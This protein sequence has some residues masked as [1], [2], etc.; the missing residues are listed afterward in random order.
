M[1]EGEYE[2]CVHYEFPRYAG[3]MVSGVQKIV[4]IEQSKFLNP[5]TKNQVGLYADEWHT[6]IKRKLKSV[7][8]FFKEAY[9]LNEGEKRLAHY[10]FNEEEM[11]MYNWYNTRT[12]IYDGEN[13]KDSEKGQ[14]WKI[15][16]A[17]IEGSMFDGFIFLYKV[18]K[19]R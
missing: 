17:K 9:P 8:K 11:M 13:L 10:I 19:Y 1:E 6:P 5:S 3:V 12:K 15:P 14:Y 2:R 18:S 7:A 4:D 16:N